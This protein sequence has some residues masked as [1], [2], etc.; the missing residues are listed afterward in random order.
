MKTNRTMSPYS[1]PIQVYDVEPL[2]VEDI[3]INAPA[4]LEGDTMGDNL[5]RYSLGVDIDTFN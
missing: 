3:T 4:M 1:A 2:E 5:A